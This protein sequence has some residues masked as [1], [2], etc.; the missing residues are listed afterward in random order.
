MRKKTYILFTLLLLTSFSYSQLAITWQ[1]CFGGSQ[2]ERPGD[3]VQCENENFMIIGYT[4]S[5]DGD[6][7]FNHG[8][9]DVW[10][11]KIDNWGDIIYEKTFGGSDGDIGQRILKD[12]NSNYFLLND[13]WSSDFDITF[14]PY[15]QSGDYWIVK[16]DSSWS[17]I[18]DKIYGGTW[19][20][21]VQT[22]VVTDNNDLIVQGYTGS[23]D[24]D[25]SAYYGQYDIWQIKLNNNGE[26]M[27]D[28]TIG[29]L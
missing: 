26:L 27:Q 1:N 3:I 12:Y 8:D 9:Y 28:F 18:W 4:G 22:G 24:G 29:S 23:P 19:F 25:V 5:S 13:A 21:G 7:S 6:V 17:I 16:I 10:L 15:P 14:D 11:V 2:E 20:D